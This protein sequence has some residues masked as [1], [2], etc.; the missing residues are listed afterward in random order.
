MDLGF[1]LSINSGALS[2]SNCHI[3][4]LLADLLK[5]VWALG[6]LVGLPHFSIVNSWGP[7]EP[8]NSYTPS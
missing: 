4:T 1:R 8:Y 5:H 3:M 6:K 7:L 2:I